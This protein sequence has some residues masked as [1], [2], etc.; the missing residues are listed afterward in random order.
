MGTGPRMTHGS[1]CK[2]SRRVEAIPGVPVAAV[3]RAV[4]LREA[5]LREAVRQERVRIP[6]ATKALE[7]VKAAASNDAGAVASAPTAVK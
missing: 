5:A 2:A 6:A 4:A 1:C 7:V 3:P